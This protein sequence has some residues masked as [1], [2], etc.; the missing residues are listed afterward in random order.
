MNL[1]GHLPRC[2]V[3]LI[4][5]HVKVEAGRA[6]EVTI[7]NVPCFLYRTGVTVLSTAWARCLDIAFGGSFFALVDA[8][9]WG[10]A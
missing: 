4:K 8:D 6:V 3:R 5:A 2:A 9:A 1:Y 10:C 7:T